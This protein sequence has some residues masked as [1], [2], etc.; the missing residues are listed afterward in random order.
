MVLGLIKKLKNKK[1]KPVAN[2]IPLFVKRMKFLSNWRIFFLNKDDQNA[3]IEKNTLRNLDNLSH[4]TTLEELTFKDLLRCEH[5]KNVLRCFTKVPSDLKNSGNDP[6]Y[7]FKI[8]K[9]SSFLTKIHFVTFQE[10]IW[11]L[12]FKFWIIL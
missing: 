6:T 12:N 8:C 7:Q 3:P 4:K 9:I 1:L 5:Y 10:F 2:K 11:I